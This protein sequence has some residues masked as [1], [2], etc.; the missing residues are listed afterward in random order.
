MRADQENGLLRSNGLL[1]LRMPHQYQTN[2]VPGNGF[3]E[4][5]MM[6]PTKEQIR[7][8]LISVIE[9]VDCVGDQI[10]VAGDRS[11]ALLG[12]LLLRHI[13]NKY[14]RQ[15]KN[16]KRWRTDIGWSLELGLADEINR[17]LPAGTNDGNHLYAGLEALLES[18]R[19]IALVQSYLEIR[20]EPK[21]EVKP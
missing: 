10:R 11:G 2:E 8:G 16:H 1:R 21:A 3:S 14:A 15:L 9:A 5:G 20:T 18:L 4:Q 12:G 17:L 6:K 13:K 19:A 7:A